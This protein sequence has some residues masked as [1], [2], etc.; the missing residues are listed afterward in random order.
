VHAEH[1]RGPPARPRDGRDAQGG[2]VGGEHRVVGHRALEPGEQVALDGEVLDD[3]LDHQPTPGERGEVGRARGGRQARDGGVGVG[4]RRAALLDLARERPR[5]A[6]AGP[7]GSVGAR[8]GEDDG[9]A[10]AERDL[11]DPSAHRAG[12]EDADGRASIQRVGC[13]LVGQRAFHGC[14]VLGGQRESGLPP[15]PERSEGPTLLSEGAS[16]RTCPPTCTS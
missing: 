9:V 6:L 14:W 15:H 3:G 12:A 1:A 13:V 2:R 5:D 4:P 8:V 10:G 11:G 7:L 16:C